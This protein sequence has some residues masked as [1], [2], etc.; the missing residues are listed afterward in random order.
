MGNLTEREIDKIVNKIINEAPID[1]DG[2]E[3][4]DP[5]I[6]RKILDIS[7]AK[8]YGWKPKISLNEG[9]QSIYKSFLDYKK[10]IN[11]NI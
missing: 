7:I 8:K 11:K 5:S 9:F 3:R 4:M 6:E 1:Y 10:K 2:P